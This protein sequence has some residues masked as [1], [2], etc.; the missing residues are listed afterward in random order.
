MLGCH[1]NISTSSHHQRL[2]GCHL[3]IS[4][5]SHHQ[6]L[7]GDVTLRFNLGGTP[8]LFVVLL[9]FLFIQVYHLS[10]VEFE[11]LCHCFGGW[12]LAWKGVQVFVLLDVPLLLSFKL[13]ILIRCIFFIFIFTRIYK[14]YAMYNNARK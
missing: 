2:L 6:S 12:H 8:L 7:L 13:I 1:L 3:N 14:A 5:S 9:D 10:V 11:S 4:T